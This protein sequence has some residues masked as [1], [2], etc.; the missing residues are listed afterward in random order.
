MESSNAS[1]IFSGGIHVRFCY[2]EESQLC[3]EPFFETFGIMFKALSLAINFV[4]FLV[5]QRLENIQGTVFYKT[6]LITS[7]FDAFDGL[8]KV[9]ATI[10][11]LRKAMVINKMLRNSIVICWSLGSSLKYYILMVST[12]DRWLSLAKPFEYGSLLVIRL[13]NF[14]VSLGAVGAGVMIGVSC[15]MYR[16]VLCFTQAFGAVAEPSGESVIYGC[17]LTGAHFLVENLFIVLII[18]QLIQMNRRSIL[19]GTDKQLRQAAKYLVAT[20]I[21][22]SVCLSGFLVRNI[23]VVG[24]FQAL[25]VQTNFSCYVFL[26]NSSYG[27]LNIVAFAIYTSGYRNKVREIWFK[28]VRRGR[29]ANDDI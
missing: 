17:V 9:L 26:L 10:C 3:M 7:A 23:L 11:S 15:I 8:I 16:D 14:F 21:L 18:R 13:F 24:G 4:H 1:N 12:V 27:F 6:L 22:Y 28:M 29:V 19:S 25:I 5:I 20:A 2:Q